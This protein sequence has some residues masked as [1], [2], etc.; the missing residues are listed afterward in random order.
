MRLD[1]IIY[2][3]KQ[4]HLHHNGSHF[5][6]LRLLR[7]G[8][9]GGVFVWLS[10]L[11]LP[12]VK[13]LECAVTCSTTKFKQR[14]SRCNRQ[15]KPIV[16]MNEPGKSEES[17]WHPHVSRPLESPIGHGKPERFDIKNNKSTLHPGRLSDLVQ[18]CLD[19]E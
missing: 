10:R 14:Q 2:M 4:Q 3:F 17:P 11:P 15:D 13:Y 1:I 19:R 5:V 9:V 12:G 8:W 7:E 18:P 6:L 16:N